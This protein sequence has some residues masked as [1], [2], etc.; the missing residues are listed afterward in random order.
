MRKSQT[1]V[2]AT[3]AQRFRENSQTMMIGRLHLS[4][5]TLVAGLILLLPMIAAANVTLPDVINSSMVLQRDRP[6][7]IWGQA[8]PGESVTV[9]FGDQ[10]KTVV[11]G[12]DGKWS[13]RL[14]ALHANAT[15]A[16]M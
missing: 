5:S 3:S 10:I 4:K 7:S 15:P 9:R 16:T 12:A 1:E 2:C 11:A 14:N 13:V 8:D 6:V